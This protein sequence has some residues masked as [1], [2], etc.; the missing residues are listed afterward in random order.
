MLIVLFIQEL[1]DLDESFRESYLPLLDRFFL[2][3]E[4]IYKYH[5]DFTILMDE[6]NQGIFIQYSIEV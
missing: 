3:F 2:L 6:I 5:A 4:S 1:L